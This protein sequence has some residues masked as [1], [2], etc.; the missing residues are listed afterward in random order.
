MKIEL[1][2]DDVATIIWAMGLVMGRDR[3]KWNLREARLWGL[4]KYL[5]QYV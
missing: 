3:K 2:K 4:R 5:E 1:S